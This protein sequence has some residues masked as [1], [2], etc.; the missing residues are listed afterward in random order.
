M[1]REAGSGRV[2]ALLLV[3]IALAAMAEV[4]AGRAVAPAPPAPASEIP[5]A[6]A[7]TPRASSAEVLLRLGD[8]ARRRGDAPAARRAYL[9]ALFRARGEGSLPG[10]VAAAEAFAALGDE[11]VVQQAVAMAE[12]LATA[13]GAD[14]TARAR[15]AA[16]RERG[17]P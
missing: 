4:V 3:V 17:A 15:L 11:A 16:L 6:V 12:P 7:E 5:R 10:V 9:V 8:E 2:I 1:E 13:P 14:A